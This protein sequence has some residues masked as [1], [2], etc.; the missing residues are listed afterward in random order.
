MGYLSSPKGTMFAVYALTHRSPTEPK[1]TQVVLAGP[2]PHFPWG[3]G[4]RS[5]LNTLAEPRVR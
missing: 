1:P 2:G 5:N 3:L 4:Q